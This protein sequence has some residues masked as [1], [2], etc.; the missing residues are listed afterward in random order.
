MRGFLARKKYT[1]Q[2]AAAIKLQAA[3]RGMA[4]RRKVRD[5]RRNLAATK[6]QVRD[7]EG[8][9][10]GERGRGAVRGPM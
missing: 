10:R 6:I 1:E 4:G 2:K 7:G 3:A 9:K 8:G 5:M